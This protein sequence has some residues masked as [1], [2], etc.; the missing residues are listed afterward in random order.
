MTGF[1]SVLRALF[2]FAVVVGCQSASAREMVS[3][4]GSEVNMRSGP[5]KGYAT[6]W[7]L[8]RGYPLV[9]TGRKGKW[10][11]VE[12]FEG[13]RGWVWSTLVNHSPH[14]VVSTSVLNLRASPST[15]ARILGKA[16]YGDVLRTL[17]R[18]GRWVKVTHKSGVKGWVS[19][20]LV[21]GW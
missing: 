3:I 16:V 18:R 7:A 1:M 2:A 19:N 9:V 8:A 4:S 17:D 20:R 6:Q 15:R 14:M 5:G 11:H 21:W 13:D 12:D 10:L